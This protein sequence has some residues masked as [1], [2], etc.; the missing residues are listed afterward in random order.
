MI[1]KKLRILLFSSLLIPS[2]TIAQT[3]SASTLN[4]GSL[5]SASNSGYVNSAIGSFV[6]GTLT[7]PES[8]NQGSITQGFIQSYAVPQT[9]PVQL[10]AI[11][12]AAQNSWTGLLNTQAD[13]DVCSMNGRVIMVLPQGMNQT[14][15]LDQLNRLQ[16]AVYVLRSGFG[17][18]QVRMIFSPSIR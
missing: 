7:D 1:M 8:S 18:S 9:A 6:A 10:I 5:Q 16:P 11:A 4:S 17:T 15:L 14:M 2:L 3:I 12:R 13:I